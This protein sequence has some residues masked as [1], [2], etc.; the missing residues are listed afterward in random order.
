MLN[1]GYFKVYPKRLANH[2]A[3]KLNTPH[4]DGQPSDFSNFA[5][6]FHLPGKE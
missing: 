4:R 2:I 6:S 1:A 3:V 5:N